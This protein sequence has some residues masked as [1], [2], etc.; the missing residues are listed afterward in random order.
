VHYH[1]L[2]EWNEGEQYLKESLSISRKTNNAQQI[3]NSYGWL[4]W[5]HYDRGDYAKAKEYFD[6][7][8]EVYEKTGQKAYQVSNYDWIAMNL[9]ELGEIDE[10]KALLDEMHK[11][12]RKQDTQ[13]IANEDAT[14]ARLLRAEKKWNES[15]ELF[16]KSLQEYED[17]GARQWNVYWLAKTVLYEYALAYMERN[18][19][20]DRE[21]AHDLLSQALEIF[22]KMGAKKEV[23]KT[24][25]LM[26][27]LQLP[28]KI[29]ASEGAVGSSYVCDEVRGNV[30]ASQREL[31]I[32]E[33]LDVEIEVKNTRKEG[34]ILLTKIIEIIPEGFAIAKKP[35]MYRVVGNCLIMREKPLDPS[36]T[37]VVKLVLTPKVQGTFHMK[38]KIVYLDESGKEKTC[39]PKPISITV[40]ELGIKGWLKGGR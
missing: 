12:A 17:L 14:R 36:K 30:I 9:I 26:E 33:S 32:G 5:C 39:E 15:I 20:G 25:R 21:K 8:S 34:T 3:S 10:A 27:G 4:G 7:M 23:E 28:P 11:F 22:L 1:W 38:P 24:M 35:E 31:K 16:E 2:G 19:P 37:E 13:L 29:Q 18:Q 6:R 40:K